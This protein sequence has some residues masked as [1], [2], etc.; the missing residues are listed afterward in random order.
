[1]TKDEI[2]F[3]LVEKFFDHVP[4]PEHSEFEFGA[5]F[6]FADR[7]FFFEG[8]A[9]ADARIRVRPSG[10]VRWAPYAAMVVEEMGGR[11]AE[12][13]A[14]WPVQGG[15]IQGSKVPVLA[16]VPADSLG[17]ARSAAPPA[18]V[19]IRLV[20]YDPHAV[21]T[22]YADPDLR[23]RFEDNAKIRRCLFVK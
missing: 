2:L 13:A 23:S 21:A 9:P 11:L 8:L 16:F 6:T 12:H 3:F 7:K 4:R 5:N 18:A 22:W 19:E 17:A 15:E 10:S 20:G 1:M 14:R